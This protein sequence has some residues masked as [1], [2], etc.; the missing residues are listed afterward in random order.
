MMCRK[1]NSSIGA[2]L[3]AFCAWRERQ[4]LCLAFLFYEDGQ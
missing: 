1:Q 2:A 3:G 4:C